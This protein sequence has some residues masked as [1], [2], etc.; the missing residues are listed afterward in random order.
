MTSH[1]RRS[2]DA[3]ASVVSV[4]VAGVSLMVPIVRSRRP[5]AEGTFGPPPHPN[6]TLQNGG[7]GNAGD[8]DHLARTLIIRYL[9]SHADV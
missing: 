7:R 9:Y 8:Q 2:G 6:G 3:T 5:V 4:S 1:F